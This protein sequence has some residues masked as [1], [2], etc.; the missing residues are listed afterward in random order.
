MLDAL[1]HRYGKRP[2]ELLKDRNL[3]DLSLDWACYLE[4]KKQSQKLI[5]S[6]TANLVIAG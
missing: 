1:G 3:E 6:G 4:G 5:D 2:T